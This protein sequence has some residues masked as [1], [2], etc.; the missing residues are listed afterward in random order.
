VRAGC[1]DELA[2][3]S[4][5]L[6]T[7]AVNGFTMDEAGYDA[8]APEGAPPAEEAA[9]MVRTY[10]ESLPD[11]HFSN[12]KEVAE[13]FAMTDQDARFDLLIHIFIDGIAA[14]ES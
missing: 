5:L 13:H 3:Q 7:S 10:F 11:E 2:A 6:M 9:Q 12:L 4:Y 14:Q 8:Q 1:L